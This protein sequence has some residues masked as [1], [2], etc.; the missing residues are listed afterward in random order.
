MSE[1]RIS[2][3]R[4][5]QTGNAIKT[6]SNPFDG[7]ITF[8]TFGSPSLM[9]RRC[10]HARVYRP[11]HNTHGISDKEPISKKFVSERNDSEYATSCQNDHPRLEAGRRPRISG[12]LKFLRL[13]PHPLSTESRVWCTKSFQVPKGRTRAL[14]LQ[15]STRHPKKKEG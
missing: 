8:E 9:F 6:L 11:V 13:L 12:H 14:D 5:P 1:S 3:N 10:I 7:G 2:D 4:N 15:A